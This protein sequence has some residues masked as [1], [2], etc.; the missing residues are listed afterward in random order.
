[1]LPFVPFNR[2]LAYYSTVIYVCQAFF[3]IFLKNFF[4]PKSNLLNGAIIDR[5]HVKDQKFYSLL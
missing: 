3:E 4:V 2:R 1:M 5:L